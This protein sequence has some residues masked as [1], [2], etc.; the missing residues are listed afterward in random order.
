MIRWSDSRSTPIFGAFQWWEA[1]VQ[2]WAF[3]RQDKGMDREARFRALFDTAYAPLCR[4]A[5]H[6]GM[7]GADA[8]DLVAQTLEIAWRRIEDV[9]VADPLPWLFAVARNLWRNQVRLARR[10]SEILARFRASPPA[11]AGDDPA[12]L[13]PGLLRAA[14]A[15]L[16][17]G[18]QEVLRLVAWDGLTPA[19]VAIVLD[20]SA[21]AARSRLHRARARLAARLGLDTGPQRRAPSAQAPGDGLDLEEAQQ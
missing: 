20:C 2:R 16:S 1:S 9:P 8:E 18:D 3:L 17:E 10:R 5:R 13:E 4:Y 7:A 21:V 6:R 11:A 15:S 19:E 12:G 14:M